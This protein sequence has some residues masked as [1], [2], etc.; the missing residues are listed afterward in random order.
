MDENK[1]KS[2]QKMGIL[3][4]DEKYKYYKQYDSQIM[5]FSDEY[6]DK[7]PIEELTK[8]DI[9]SNSYLGNLKDVRNMKRIAA[10]LE[11]IADALEKQS[12]GEIVIDGDKL[13]EEIK[14]SAIRR[15]KGLPK[16]RPKE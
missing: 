2:I 5:F 13:T 6:L 8:K 14:N 15:G 1:R 9:I 7:M 16:L 11:R 3:P 4:I 12:A 10:S